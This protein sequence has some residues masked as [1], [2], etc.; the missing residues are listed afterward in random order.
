MI[1]D[2][3]EYEQGTRLETDI[4]I[5]GSGAAGITIAREFVGSAHRVLVLEAGG[6]LFEKSSQDPYQSAVV[7]LKHGGI[8][9]GR[10]R[11]LGGATTLWAGQA[12]RLFD[13]DFAKR[14]W[15]P[16]SGW[17]IDRATLDPFYARAEQVMQIPHAMNEQS[18]WPPFL[19]TPPAYDVDNIVTYYSQFT[20]VPNFSQKY[21]EILA[22]ASNIT[23]VMHANVTSLAANDRATR[24][25]EVQARGLTGHPVSVR[26]KHFIVCCGGIES[27]RL[28]L[29]SNALEKTGIGNR[30]DVVGRFFQDHPGVAIPIKPLDSARFHSLYDSIR[31]SGIKYSV[32][33]AASADF[34]KRNQILHV[35]SEVYYPIGDDDPLKA[36]RDVLKGARQRQA[37]PFVRA[38]ARVMARP[39]V[40]AGAAFR[41]YVRRQPAS[42][43]STLPHLGV[44]GE[45]QPN[46]SSRIT[47][48]EEVDVLGLPRTRLDWRL[49]PE[50]SQSILSFV[51]DL[52]SEWKRLR[53]AEVDPD[54]VQILGRNE[55][56]HGGYVD[57]NHHMG[58]TRMGTDPTTSVVDARCRVH[59]YT[60]LYIGSSSVFP[61]GGF[62]NPTLTV[63]A[64]CLRIADD[65]KAQLNSD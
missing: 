10:V 32:K 17:P 35:G 7:G 62:S 64:L 42:V 40:V 61:T 25:D 8:H 60:N 34:Q 4:C 33:L 30:H 55:G 12:L 58:T 11:V 51:R 9:E 24:L 43:G 44:G 31:H 18:S 45:Q 21:R 39:D 50:D 22:S 47:L 28:L 14:S 46:P 56:Q 19:S 13:I 2:I 6:K 53:I 37:G 59:G 26:A 52:A 49:T 57:A 41:R 1:V 54:A 36:A 65:I 15:V 27:A 63:L 3:R 29:L 20:S 38:L 48:G 5:I 23:L 16:Y